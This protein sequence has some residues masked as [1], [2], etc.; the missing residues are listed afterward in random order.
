MSNIL[1]SNVLVSCAIVSVYTLD[2]NSTGTPLQILLCT[3][4]SKKP[5]NLH[6]ILHCK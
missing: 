1:N 2:N 4:T 6:A 3:S 5:R